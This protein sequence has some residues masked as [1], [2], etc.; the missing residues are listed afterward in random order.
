MVN[1]SLFYMS[2]CAMDVTL[3]EA[4]HWQCGRFIVTNTNECLRS[5]SAKILSIPAVIEG[6]CKWG[7]K[8]VRANPMRPLLGDD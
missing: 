2:I 8:L 4:W 6:L 7:V 3:S 1:N 5:K